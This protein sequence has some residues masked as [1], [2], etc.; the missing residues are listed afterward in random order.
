MGGGTRL[1]H[2]LE[3]M[4]FKEHATTNILLSGFRL[5]WPPSGCLDESTPFAR[6]F[7]ADRPKADHILSGRI[8]RT[9]GLCLICGPSKKTAEGKPSKRA[10]INQRPRLQRDCPFAKGHDTTKLPLV[11]DER[12]F[13]HL[14]LAFGSSRIASSAYQ[15]W[16]TSNGAFKCPR[17]TK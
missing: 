14:N 16:P 8:T 13:R 1:V 7:Q 15:K 5:P 2:S 17:S 6:S 12:T 3:S 4:F 10:P 11:S 9:A